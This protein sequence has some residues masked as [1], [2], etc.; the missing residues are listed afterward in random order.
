MPFLWLISQTDNSGYDTYDSA[1]V[2][3]ATEQDARLIHPDADSRWSGDAWVY[4]SGLA[5]WM[6]NGWTTPEKVAVE[7]IGIP[8]TGV[9]EGAV[10][11]ASFNAG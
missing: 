5:V 7:Q 4:E 3:A 10:I 11:C 2:C 9:R 8:S 1:V 6:D